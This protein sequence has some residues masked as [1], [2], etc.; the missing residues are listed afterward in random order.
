M[1]PFLLLLTLIAGVLLGCKGEDK[2]SPDSASTPKSE[3]KLLVYVSNYPLYYF[4][5]RI[6]GTQIV[7]R[8]PMKS[9]PDPATW[10]PVA[11]SV[12]AMQGA[13]LIL[14]NGAT[15]ESWLMNVSLP[16]SLLVD[17]STG[18][19]TRLLPSGETFTHSHGEDGAHSHEGVAW[20]TWLDL[21]LAIQQAEAVKK[22]LIKRR[23]QQRGYFEGRYRELAAELKTLDTDFRKLTAAQTPPSLVYAHPIFAYFQNAYALKGPSLNWEP[24]TPLNHDMLHEIDHLKKEKGIRVM[25]WARSPLKASSDELAQR[26]IQSVVVQPLQNT[27]ESGDFILQMQEALKALQSLFKT[28]TGP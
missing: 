18:Y 24:E 6:G 15:Y 4:A 17:T 5:E 23:P 16:D 3:Q 12:A 2:S 28:T 21:S 1:K 25:V 27:P 19:A 8:Y 26:G 9:A 13:D 7:L 11:D 14:L 10:T 20:A 22:A